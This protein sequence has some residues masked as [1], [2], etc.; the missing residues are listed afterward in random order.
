MRKK[1]CK[2]LNKAVYA[3]TCIEC[4]KL[5]ETEQ[6]VRKV[7]PMF[8]RGEN[9]TGTL[10]MTA[11]YDTIGWECDYLF[12]KVVFKGPH[13]DKWRKRFGQSPEPP[14]GTMVKYQYGNNEIAEYANPR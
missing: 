12:E 9:G 1:Y 4:G 2:L 5:R 11:E 6:P 3:K 7:S 13:T 8:T 10:I 14:V